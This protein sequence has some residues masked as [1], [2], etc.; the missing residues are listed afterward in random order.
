MDA[1]KINNL[2]HSLRP[3]EGGARTGTPQGDA[4]FAA[5]IAAA[6]VLDDLLHAT[7][8]DPQGGVVTP[9]VALTPRTGIVVN[10][11]TGVVAAEMAS[12]LASVVSRSPDAE[13]VNAATVASPVPLPAPAQI[14]SLTE[15]LGETSRASVFT[16]GSKSPPAAEDRRASDVLAASTTAPQAEVRADVFPLLPPPG[17]PM[18]RLEIAEQRSS[19]ATAIEQARDSERLA[20][21]NAKGETPIYPRWLRF[22]RLVL[23]AI[24]LGLALVILL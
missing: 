1:G 10:L 15:R 18:N 8:N 24:V 9:A 17:M 11:S 7:E 5:K 12:R 23:A 22:D 3:G 4:A 2:I 16:S 20:G 6:A 14:Y 21:L 13:R 19:A